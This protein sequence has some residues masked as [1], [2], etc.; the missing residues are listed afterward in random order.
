MILLISLALAGTDVILLLFLCSG[1]GLALI[2]SFY[3][4]LDE[5]IKEITYDAVS[6]S[7]M[8]PACTAAAEL[9]YDRHDKH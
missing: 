2:Q 7:N 4:A 9:G 1:G 8:P 3:T 6:V 5:R